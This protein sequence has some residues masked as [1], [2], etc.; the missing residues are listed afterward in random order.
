MESKVIQ[1]LSS[2]SDPFLAKLIVES[3]KEVEK[4]F[5]LKSWKTSELDAGHFVEAVRRFIEYNLFG[6]YTPIGKSLPS[7]NERTLQSYLNASG[8][9]SYRIHIPRILW[10]IYGIRNKRGVG[11]L[12][13]INPNYLDATV[14]IASVKWV[15]AEL[16]RINSPLNPNEIAPIIENIVE[17]PVEGIWEQGDITRILVDGL[18]IKEQIIFLLFSTKLKEDEVLRKTIEYDNKGYFL[19]VIKKLHT[20]RLI[21]YDANTGLITLSPKGIHFA[22]QLIQEKIQNAA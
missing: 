1:A 22:E 19:R 5:F 6:S 11:H 12:S 7:F 8:D 14:I 2:A 21:E 10:A 3:F 4:N 18:S 15:L 20:D 13:R 17:R 9:D 16:V